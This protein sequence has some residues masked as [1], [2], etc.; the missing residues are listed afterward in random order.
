M[1]LL[2]FAA[3]DLPPGLAIGASLPPDLPAPTL[4]P[5]AAFNF[6]ARSP[7]AQR[8]PSPPPAHT[9][10]DP[11][12]R[13]LKRSPGGAAV[14]WS[15]KRHADATRLS[16]PNDGSGARFAATAL[17]QSFFANDPVSV[18]V[19]GTPPHRLGLPPAAHW[20]GTGAAHGHPG[21]PCAPV[22]AAVTASVPASA[23]EAAASSPVA[24][25]GSA[26]HAASFR[27]DAFL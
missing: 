23:A 17:P 1:S 9:P 18:A 19:A 15:S 6:G 27:W 5:V 3:Q 8:S 25:P 11:S 4:P 21:D 22:P 7:H 2:C 14:V 20:P 26:A 13:G 16:A 24:P 10:S 12:Q